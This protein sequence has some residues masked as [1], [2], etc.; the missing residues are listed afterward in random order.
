[1][2]LSRRSLTDNEKVECEDRY[3]KSKLVRSIFNQ[4]SH[5]KDIDID[6]LYENIGYPLH[7]KYGHTLD[8]LKLTI[9]DKSVLDVLKI[10]K[11]IKE[12]LVNCI[13]KRLS[14][15]E[16]RVNSLID[17]TCF[18]FKGVKAISNPLM[19][20]M[21]LSTFDIPVKIKLDSSPTYLITIVSTS[22]TDAMQRVNDVTSKIEESIKASG[23]DISIRQSPVVVS[24]RGEL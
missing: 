8:G 12:T 9:F 7:D 6:K 24:H 4:V 1:M 11:D 22:T 2:D 13:N 10:D 3:R 23:G 5:F 18:E 20:G 21:K 17:I 19:E 15:R 14:L 16:V